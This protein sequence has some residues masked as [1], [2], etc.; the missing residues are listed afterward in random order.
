MLRRLAAPALLLALT[1]AV[2]GMGVLAAQAARWPWLVAMAVACG[3]LV[4][5]AWWHGGLTTRR[6]L[7]FALL[8][9][10]LLAWL[11]PSLSDDAYRYVWDGLVQA[12]GVN[13]Y[14]YRPSDPALAHLQG[15][16]VYAPLNSKAYFSVYPPVSQGL[17]AVGG[18]V[19]GYGW[20]ASFY[21]IKALLIGMEVGALLLL[22]R[23]VAARELVLY[24][25]NPLVLLETAG[26]AHTENAMVLFLVL[27]VWFARRRQ[28]AG[29]SMAVALAGW[30]KLYPFVLLP[31]LV[32]RFGARGVW[33]GLALAAVI[34]LPYAAP[35]VLPH[36][37]TSLDLYALLFEF[38][39][40]IYYFLK[41][42]YDV[43]YGV[44]V[45]KQLG[46][47]L[48]ALFLAGLPV[49]YLL[50]AR[51]RWPLGRAMLLV[52]G[53]FLVCA[54][55]VHP[56]YLLGILALAVF[57]PSPPWHWHWLGLASIGTYLLYVGGPYWSFVA[58]GWG[59]WFVLAL[60]QTAPRGFESLQ[61]ARARR[62][63]RFIQPFLPR[64]KRPLHVL[65][66]GAGEGYVGA[67]LGEGRGVQ[68]T[69]ADVLPMNRT[70]LPHVLYDGQHLP[71]GDDAFDVTVLYFVLHHA[72]DPRAVVRE[73]LR[74]T[75]GRVV[76]VES[77]YEKAWDRHLL[78]RLDRWANRVRSRGLMRGQEEHV[79]FRRRAAWRTLFE[80]EGAT[81]LSERR[82][83]RLVHRQAAFVLAAR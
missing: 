67:I 30:V 54:T 69:L 38:N 13:P 71:F 31:L 36:L 40:G 8:F 65:D 50:D 62:K 55:T 41:E 15:E 18:L 21:L 46:P 1:L 43:L 53:W 2:A 7:V 19:Y 80:D 79:Q 28:G 44:D 35:Y 37:R 20:E 9:R 74:V 24:A 78:E 75:K 33:P 39:A 4:L 58:A 72:E 73:A 10:L 66:L 17:F 68:V 59:G 23:M 45:S 77:V 29:A 42:G 22:A 52:I 56:W 49:F 6:V 34:A 61:R 16:P 47:A 27:A 81:V 26:Q 60:V 25:W 11:P 64:I 83:G 76:V 12:E 57:R 63:I 51:H 48:R 14:Q 3:V 5:G 70:G 82:R 32:R